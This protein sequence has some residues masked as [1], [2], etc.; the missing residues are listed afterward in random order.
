MAYFQ[1][2]GKS[3]FYETWGRGK[4]ILFLHGNTASSRMFEL[5]LPLY[6]PNFRCIVMDF[7]GNGRSERVE[8]FPADL[9]HDEGR[10]AAALVEHLHCG[11]VG[12]VG[13]SGGVWAAINAALERPELVDAVAADSFDGRTLNEKFSDNLAAER[14]GAK[15]DPQARQFYQW[16]QGADW[17]QVV[18]RDTK[19]L[20][21]CAGEGRPLFIK[22]LDEL[23]APVLLMGSREDAMCRRELEREYREM[24]A[25]IPRAEVCMFAHGG[26]PAIASNAE[27]AARVITGFFSAHP[28]QLP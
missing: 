5:L 25:V 6:R 18:D 15:R 11:K 8:E 21:R 4:P 3:V 19:A 1:Y 17:E 13:T 27:E 24:A 16:C 26:H 2:Q 9:W 14:E 22:P 20:L 7:V 23:Q 28:A 12:I 10:Q